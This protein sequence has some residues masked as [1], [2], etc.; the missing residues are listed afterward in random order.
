MLPHPFHSVFR[1]LQEEHGDVLNSL[2]S[3]SG[4]VEVKGEC[5]SGSLCTA[6][7]QPRVSPLLQDNKMKLCRCLAAQLFC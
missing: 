2:G 3:D 6:V 1:A 7:E 4:H 5:P